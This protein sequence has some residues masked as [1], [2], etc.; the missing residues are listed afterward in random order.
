MSVGRLRQIGI[1]LALGSCLALGCSREKAQEPAGAKPGE[2]AAG[3]AAP[4]ESAAGAAAELPVAGLGEFPDF[5]ALP[6]V[7]VPGSFP[8]D[9]PRYPGA[10]AVKATPDPESTG[11]WVAQFSTPDDPAKVYASLADG[12]AAQGWSTERA[13]AEEGILLYA[14]RGNRSATYTISAPKGKTILSLIIME[15]D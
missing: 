6:T 8:Q 5:D 9:V 4:G 3:A 13:D 1:S 7:E 10:R 15:K 2:S 11:G 12:F 14:N